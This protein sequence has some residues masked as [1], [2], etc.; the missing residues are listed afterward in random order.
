LAIASLLSLST[1]K[2]EILFFEKPRDLLLH[3]SVINKPNPKCHETALAATL[4]TTLSA[5]A[6]VWI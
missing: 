3:A 2:I 1:N 4:Q 6:I 5:P